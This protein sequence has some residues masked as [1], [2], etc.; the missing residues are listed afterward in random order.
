MS[1][2][3]FSTKLKE[4]K[5][6]RKANKR[7]AII[8][9]WINAGKPVPT[10][11]EVKQDAI[12]HY[13]SV[14][15][16]GT[17]VETGTFRGEMVEAQRKRFNHIYSIELGEKLWQTA[18]KLFESYNH[19]EILLGDSGK[20]LQKITHKLSSPAIFWLDGHYSA[21]E[22]AKGDKECPIFEEIDAIFMYGTTLPHVLLVDDARCFIGQGDY[23]AIE[24]L[25]NY[26]RS[27]NGAY[28]VEVKDDIIRYTQKYLQ[29]A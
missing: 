3:L 28:D 9:K 18:V 1:G 11:H 21:G 27:K 24:E 19:V 25:T 23:P 26:I 4:F 2:N 20:V 8:E 29:P 10:P 5:A 16:I 17:L 14:Y 15:G 22:T 13:Q 6:Q 7:A 12:A